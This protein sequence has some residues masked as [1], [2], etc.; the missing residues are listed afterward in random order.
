MEHILR[1]DKTMQSAIEGADWSSWE[2]PDKES[3]YFRVKDSSK[4]MEEGF[5]RG[6]A[7]GVPLDALH[8]VDHEQLIRIVGNRMLAHLQQGLDVMAHGEP[9]PK[10]DLHI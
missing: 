6:V 7:I 3:V 8:Y 2:D 9:Y 1:S 5:S 10:E 4:Y